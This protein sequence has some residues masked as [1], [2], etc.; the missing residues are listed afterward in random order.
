VQPLPDS[1]S[2]VGRQPAEALRAQILQTLN[3]IIDPCSAA[4]AIP[5]G[6][7]DMG[8]IR[9]LSIEP[10]E[11]GGWR[12]RV[13]LCVT[14]ALCMMTG[15]FINEIERRLG[16][17]TDVADVTV[18]L[19]HSTIW[20]EELMSHDYRSRLQELRERRKTK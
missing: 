10:G 8:L 17:L 14:H 18:E 1:I 4:S 15:V 12:C 3:C 2:A 19:D 7:V 5:A 11:D 6:L 20:T 9:E 16:E 13:K